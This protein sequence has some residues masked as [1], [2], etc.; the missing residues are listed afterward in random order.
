MTRKKIAT[1]WISG[2][3]ASGKTTLGKRL[4]ADLKKN[5]ID[6]VKFLDG[7]DLRKLINKN[8]G[9]SIEE[10]FKLL[11]DYIS[12]VHKENTEGN[13]VVI[14]T[15]SHKSE[16]R[17]LAR[18]RLYNFFEVNLKC[19]P[20]ICAERDFKGVY[21]SISSEDNE[22]LPGVTEP[23]EFTN[24]PELILDTENNSIEYCNRI[25]FDKV[26]IFLQ[27]IRIYS[28]NNK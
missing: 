12:I 22:C 26:L 28:N 13:I 20:Q 4:A 5:E 14:A 1:I 15:V 9:H 17:E 3:T 8:Y 18:G 11:Q 6:N 25:L 16:M 27:G 23:Y 24:S 19:A 21:S 7:E 2:V 10:R